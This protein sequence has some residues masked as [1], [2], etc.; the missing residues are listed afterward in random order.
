MIPSSKPRGCPAAVV[1]SDKAPW[2]MSVGYK[3]ADTHSGGRRKT[4]QVNGI[5]NNLRPSGD[6]SL[7]VPTKSKG[8]HRA[9]LHCVCPRRILRGTCYSGLC[10]DQRPITE[11]IGQSQADMRRGAEA[12]TGCL[13]ECLMR[14]NISKIT[15]GRAA[16][17]RLKDSY[18]QTI[19]TAD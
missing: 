2:W 19:L 18:I 1:Q 7:G 14:K 4:A 8:A 12:Q 5:G 17:G 11:R 10:D 13:P 16:A 9:W 6:T 3:Q 15:V